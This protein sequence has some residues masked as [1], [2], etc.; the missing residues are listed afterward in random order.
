MNSANRHTS[1][2]RRNPIVSVEVCRCLT[3]QGFE[4]CVFH[5]FAKDYLPFFEVCR[6]GG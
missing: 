1:A 4:V 3:E 2:N 6:F 5:N